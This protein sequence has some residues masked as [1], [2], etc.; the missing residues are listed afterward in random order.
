MECLSGL[1]AA[2]EGNGG[3]WPLK[4]AFG[5]NPDLDLSGER[6]TF[7]IEPEVIHC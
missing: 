1:V 3:G 2:D 7:P 4:F 6:C 5:C